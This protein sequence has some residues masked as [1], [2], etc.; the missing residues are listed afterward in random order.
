MAYLH[1]MPL[2]TL[3]QHPLDAELI[4]VS[5]ASKSKFIV[6]IDTTSFPF[7]CHALCGIATVPWGHAERLQKPVSH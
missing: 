4:L 3:R 7:A 5:R 1:H 2:S 6:L